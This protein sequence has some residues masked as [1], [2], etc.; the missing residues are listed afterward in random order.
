M[1][2]KRSGD[3]KMKLRII[4]TQ[5]SQDNLSEAIQNW[6]REHSGML[7][8]N[9]YIEVGLDHLPIKIIKEEVEVTKL[10]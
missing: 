9:E 10:T 8:P 6:M 5:I 7:F 3:R 1:K 4:E 2:R